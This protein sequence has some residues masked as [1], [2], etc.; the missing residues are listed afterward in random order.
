MM[1]RS[2]QQHTL[3]KPA[4]IEG[5][6]LFTGVPSKC[7]IRPAAV[8]HGLVFEH[9]GTQI[10]LGAGSLC[11]GP[12]H[13]VFASVPPRC[14][15]VSSGGSSVWLVEH[16]LSA[17]AGLGISNAVVSVDHHELPILDGSSQAFVRAILD[18]G[19][20]DQDAAVTPIQISKTVRVEHG[21]SW[22]EATP[23]ASASYQ[24]TIDYGEKSPIKRATVGWDGDA[25][26]YA[27][28]VAP[29]RTFC[30][31]QEAEML[32]GGGL[33]KHL[34]P[35]D[36]LVL[37]ENGPMDNELRDP[38]ECAHHKLLDLIGD[39]ALFGSR[40]NARFVAHK[41]GHS[42]A[43]ALVRAIADSVG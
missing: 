19:V 39:V 26:D 18:A 12:V 31:K 32:I 33:F 13:P 2:D 14:S 25:A 30:L 8:D 6:A 9:N 17:L 5:V 40:I 21:D 20:V 42:M 27:H 15:A 3:A 43:H 41:S 34:A 7:T 16:V 4:L 36:M 24:Y 22:I 23:A 28:R 1:H 29:A 11:D 37:D 35:G 38:D 10:P